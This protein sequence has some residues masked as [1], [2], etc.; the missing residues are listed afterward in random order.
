MFPVDGWRSEAFTRPTTAF[1]LAISAS[2]ENAN[3]SNNKRNFIVVSR[4]VKTDLGFDSTGLYNKNCET[5]MKD[6]EERERLLYNYGGLC[7]SVC[8]GKG[9]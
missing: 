1:G 6:D 8:V 3:A 9:V 5:S 7:C 4:N 2:H